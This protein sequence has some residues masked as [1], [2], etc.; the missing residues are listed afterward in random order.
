M[1]RERYN[2]DVKGENWQITI[3]FPLTCYHVK[4]IMQ[5]LSLIDCNKTDM[6]KAW[7]NLTSGKMNNGLTFS[8]Y[9]LRKSVI[10]FAMSE[11]KEE[12]FNLVL[13]E[14]HHLAVQIGVA[15]NMNLEGEGVCYIN[16]DVGMMMF[17][18]VRYLF[19]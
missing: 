3:F 18:L 9:E 17:P 13:H 11:S 10:V 16:G 4:K 7:R 12:Y 6:R 19:C 2:I 14:L 5:E 8:N 1:I 15:N